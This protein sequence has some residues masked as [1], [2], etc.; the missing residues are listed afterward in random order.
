MREI[1]FSISGSIRIDISTNSIII[2]VNRTSTVVQMDSPIESAPR[3]VLEQGT[4]TFDIILES[5]RELLRR[6]NGNR[7]RAGDLYAIAK[8]KYPG[9]KKRSFTTRIT[10]ATPNHSS[11][12]HH[13]SHRDYFSRI[14][15][16]IYTL[17]D[18]YAKKVPAEESVVELNPSI[19]TFREARRR[20]EFK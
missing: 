2:T 9:L 6:G 15:P 13:L 7:F 11:Y 8:E 3:L 1:P 4:S 12:K 10:A 17:E 20:G 14:A 5:A 19:D 16:G 18:R